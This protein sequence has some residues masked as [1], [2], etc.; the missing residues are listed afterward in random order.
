M[1]IR[2]FFTLVILMGILIGLLI[3]W[4]EENLRKQVSLYQVLLWQIAIWT[5][6]VIGYKGIK[7]IAIYKYGSKFILP[8]LISSG[9]VWVGIHF[10]WFFLLSSNFSPYLDMP[11]TKY[12]VYPY[13]FIF[14]T[15]IDVGLIWFVIDKLLAVKIEESSLLIELTRG[16][17]KFFCTSDQ[18]YCLAAENYYTRLFTTEGIFVMRKSLKSFHD[19]L[20]SDVFKRIHRSTIINVNYVSI[21]SRGADYNLEVIMKDGTRRRVSRNFEKEINLFFKKRSY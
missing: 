10:G 13:F 1:K 7:K 12:G 11:A 20:P 19:V 3:Y 18:I 8:I 17:N 16:G 21:L 14:W 6:W 2:R 5:P 9:I 15:S 4:R